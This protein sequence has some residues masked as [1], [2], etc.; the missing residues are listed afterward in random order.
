M[1]KAGDRKKVERIIKRATKELCTPPEHQSPA[2]RR[3]WEEGVDR[4]L[5]ELLRRKS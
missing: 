2:K 3:M 4:L 1:S 5:V